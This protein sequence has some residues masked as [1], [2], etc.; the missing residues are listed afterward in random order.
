MPEKDVWNETLRHVELGQLLD[1]YGAL[2]TERQRELLNLSVNEDLSLA[3]LAEREG[4]SRQA[5]HDALRRAESSLV[6]AENRLGFLAQAK[7]MQTMLED[8]R[9]T[10]VN[11]DETAEKRAAESLQLLDTLEEIL[12][13]DE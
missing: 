5:V 10:L 6:E 13:G 1:L 4:V 11:E 9:E 8:M 3:E 7:K 2:L 12:F